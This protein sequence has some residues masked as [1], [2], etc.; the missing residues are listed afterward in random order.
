MALSNSHQAIILTISIFLIALPS[1][2]APSDFTPLEKYIILLLG[3]AG[4]AISQGFAKTNSNTPSSNL[5]DP[6]AN[7]VTL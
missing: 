6:F 1:L 2:A 5:P 3:L 7:Q 4:T